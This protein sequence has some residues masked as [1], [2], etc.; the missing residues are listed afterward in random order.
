MSFS[1]PSTLFRDQC[2]VCTHS[3]WETICD[4]GASLGEKILCSKST[5]YPILE[6]WIPSPSP[7]NETQEYPHKYRKKYCTGYLKALCVYYFSI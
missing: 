1:L 3:V 7:K 4:T 2:L 5:K 6:S